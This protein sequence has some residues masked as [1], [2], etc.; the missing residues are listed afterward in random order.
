MIIFS[1][2]NEQCLSDLNEDVAAVLRSA[3]NPDIKEVKGI[4]DRLSKL[5]KQIELAKKN[6]KEQRDL[7]AVCI[8]FS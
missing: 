4:E 8:F 6:E 2:L 3:D 5:N 7:A 1:Q